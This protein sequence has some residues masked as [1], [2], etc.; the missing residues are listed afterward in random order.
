[1]NAHQL[2]RITANPIDPDRRVRY[3]NLT[4]KRQKRYVEPPK[5]ENNEKQNRKTK[6][7][8]PAHLTRSRYSNLGGEAS[9][10]SFDADRTQTAPSR[11]TRQFK[12]SHAQSHAFDFVKNQDDKV[13]RKSEGLINVQTGQIHH[14]KR[15][16]LH[17]Q[18]TD[19]ILLRNDKFDKTD[20]DNIRFQ[21]RK[22]LTRNANADSNATPWT[23]SAKTR[24]SHNSQ[25]RSSITGQF[26]D[27]EFSHRQR[28][29]SS[30]KSHNIFE[31][32]KQESRRPSR[33]TFGSIFNLQ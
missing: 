21:Q 25:K 22:K 27:S 30:L 14:P 15:R 16:L 2:W 11:A 9:S 4:E 23:S 31:P 17:E 8:Q 5:R 26:Y 10:R 12:Q 7:K 13:N 20:A 6:V 18:K 24:S 19:T 29:H 33:S 1:M 28:K 3:K 32:Q